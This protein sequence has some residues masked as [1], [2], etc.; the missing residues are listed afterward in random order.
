MAVIAEA[1]AVSMSVRNIFHVYVDESSQTGH[2]FMV[3]GAVFCSKDAAPQIAATMEEC[4]SRHGQ[5]ASKEFHW[6][7]LTSHTLQMYKDVL[8]ALICFTIMRRKMR[9]R[10]LVIEM[11]KVDRTLDGSRSRETVLAKFI[12]TLVF[13]FARSFGP[14][15]KYHVWI[16]KRADSLEDLEMDQRT[17]H[18]LNNE[19]KSKFGW[20]QG[21]F[22]SVK[23]V[24]SKKSR[25]IQAADMIT[26]AVAY[27]TNQKHKASNAS[28]HRTALLQHVIACSTLKTLARQSPR[29]PF[30][31]QIRHFDFSKSSVSTPKR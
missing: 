4:L 27:E 24:D 3:I 14:N 1:G 5:R 29:W 31:F 7:E 10:A 2:Q 25:L 19:A 20:E 16:D 8:S 22:A 18:S 21:P 30:G 17:L 6:N 12:F 26:G 15:I 23:F 11:A 13:G 9:Y 28:K